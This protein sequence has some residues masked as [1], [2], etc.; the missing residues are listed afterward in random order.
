[1]TDSGGSTN[2][3]EKTS[4]S[5]AKSD[6]ALRTIG[7]LA[8]E[9]GIPPHVLRYWERN[10][11]V[12]RPVRLAGGRRYYRAEDVAMVRRLHHLV[13]VDGYT[14]E[15]A[16]RAVKTSARTVASAPRPAVEAPLAPTYAMPDAAAS[17]A[18]SREALIAL[19]DR[20]KAALAA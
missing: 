15:G 12:L 20:L 1:M 19:R 14:L 3:P 18:L 6:K 4:R 10:V 8:A 17:A 5:D 13:T 16:A 11:P 7:E 9:T 2:P